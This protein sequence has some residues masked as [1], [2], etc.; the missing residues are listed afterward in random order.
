MT[1]YLAGVVLLYLLMLTL[2]Y[3]FYF[4]KE[5]YLILKLYFLYPDGLPEF[6]Q[7]C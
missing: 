4:F 7:R 1:F 2:A 6:V 3:T 5:L